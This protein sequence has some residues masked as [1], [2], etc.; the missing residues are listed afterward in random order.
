M[1]T[2]ARM[3]ATRIQLGAEDEACSGALPTLP[4]RF[5]TKVKQTNGCWEWQG[6]RDSWGYGQ[7]GIGRRHY[8]VHRLSYLHFYASIPDG[9]VICHSCDNRICVNPL[10]L[11]AG[12]QA[13]NVRDMS[14]KGRNG[15]SGGKQRT[16]KAFSSG[17]QC[18]RGHV[19]V[20]ENLYQ[21]TGGRRECRTCKRD[22]RK[23]QRQRTTHPPTP[24]AR[25]A[26][27]GGFAGRRH[28]QAEC[29]SPAPC[30]GGAGIAARKGHRIQAV[31]TASVQLKVGIVATDS[32]EAVAN[33]HHPAAPADARDEC[34]VPTAPPASR[35]AGAGRVELD[36]GA[37]D[38]GRVALEWPARPYL[39]AGCRSFAVLRFPPVG[40]LTERVT[41]LGILAPA[42]LLYLNPIEQQIAAWPLWTRLLPALVLGIAL[43][44]GVWSTRNDVGGGDRGG[45]GGGGGGGG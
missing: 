4:D 37:G 5:W 45:G 44:I 31:A 9:R 19:L 20:G 25:S 26:A 8:Q 42:F 10:H 29:S 24:P 21:R 15:T 2:P 11:F 28:G 14:I 3:P 22:L 38:N 35:S 12:T 17:D 36:T 6:Y 1:D 41:A 16:A 39:T 18:G 40:R 23:A 7:I 30:A 32:A 34:T 27:R 13:D 43:I 33:G